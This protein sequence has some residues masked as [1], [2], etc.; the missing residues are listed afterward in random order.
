MLGQ[1]FGELLKVISFRKVLGYGANKEHVC[2]V[3]LLSI[4]PFT[5]C[6][7]TMTGCSLA[8]ITCALKRVVV[9][10]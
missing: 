4:L 9:G 10:D 5:H 8:A 3:F 6:F 7:P 1:P 2:N